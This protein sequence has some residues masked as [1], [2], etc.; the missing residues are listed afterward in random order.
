MIALTGYD[1]QG[2]PH[3]LK[4]FVQLRLEQSLMVP[5]D[6]LTVRVAA[7][8]IPRLS[9]LSVICGQT[10]LFDGQVDEQREVITAGEHTVTL[11]ARSAAALLLDNEA[12]CGTYNRP[13]FA[14]ILAQ[15]AKPYGIDTDQSLSARY[16]EAFT[17]SKGESEWSVLERF[18]RLV[19]GRSP[20]VE[21]GGRLN[22]QPL[23]DGEGKTI[24]NRAQGAV[25]FLA[26]ERIWKYSGLISE[27]YT[28]WG[29]EEGYTS[30]YRDTQALNLGIRRK[31]YHTLRDYTNVQRSEWARAHFKERRT[32]SDAALL[33]LAGPPAFELGERVTLLQADG[34]AGL[35]GAVAELTMECSSDGLFTFLTILPEE[36]I[37]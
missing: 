14:D 2:T 22:I 34:M 21:Q 8:N 1:F 27:I 29:Q 28:P 35:E 4:T 5:A 20:R 16:G 3:P 24:S 15:H 25:P 18:C 17:V 36:H 9:R 37:F 31:R 7:S 19:F 23:K 6:A 11:Y 26:C 30:L 13:S 10:V 32:G 12:L 33:K